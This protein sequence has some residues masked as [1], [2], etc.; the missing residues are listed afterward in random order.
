MLVVQAPAPSAES[1]V[2][3]ENSPMESKRDGCVS[4]AHSS[5]FPTGRVKRKT[6]LTLSLGQGAVLRRRFPRLNSMAVDHLPGCSHSRNSG[7]CNG[8]RNAHSTAPPIRGPSFARTKAKTDS[9]LR[10]SLP[11]GRLLLRKSPDSEMRGEPGRHRL[12]S[13]IDSSE[14]GSRSTRVFCL[15]TMCNVPSEASRTLTWRRV[16]AAV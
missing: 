1:C 4:R 11:R 9:K 2:A 3:A 10:Q 7:G 14:A 16:V 6:R 5:A 12:E 13:Q 15:T 8:D